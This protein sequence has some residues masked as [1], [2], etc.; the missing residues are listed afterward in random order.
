M[1]KER[2]KIHVKNPILVPNPH[3]WTGNVPAAFFGICVSLVL[4]LRIRLDSSTGTVLSIRRLSIPSLNQGENMTSSPEDHGEIDQSSKSQSNKFFVSSSHLTITRFNV[5]L[6]IFILQF[7]VFLTLVGVVLT[8]S[9]DNNTSSSPSMT[10]AQESLV[11]PLSVDDKDPWACDLLRAQQLLGQQDCHDSKCKRRTSSSSSDRFKQLVTPTS[12]CLLLSEGL[13]DEVCQEDH[14]NRR[15][16]FSKYSPSFCH[17]F[18]LRILSDSSWMSAN[19]S[20]CKSIL[21]TV[22][23]DILRK[24]ELARN[25]SCQ[26]NTL[27]SRY[28]CQ[29]GYSVQWS[30]SNCMVC[31]S[32]LHD[33]S[34][35]YFPSILYRKHTTIG[36]ALQSCLYSLQGYF[37]NHVTH[38]VNALKKDVHIFIHHTKNNTQENQLLY[39]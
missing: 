13:E 35:T 12:Q 18:P 5:L 8:S 33:L 24:D 37:E 39:A 21:K 28:N 25:I 11:C 16:Q 38:S 32:C 17:T 15:D 6:S 19:A 27:I 1:A 7:L 10:P 20:S 14:K 30:C 4:W 36:S 34:I 26:F 23:A 29:T 3:P 2:R 22:I 9:D 31:Y